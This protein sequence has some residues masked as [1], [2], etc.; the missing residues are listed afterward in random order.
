MAGVAAVLRKDSEALSVVMIYFLLSVGLLIMCIY[1]VIVERDISYLPVIA[2]SLIV[3]FQEYPK[4]I[5]GLRQIFHG[6]K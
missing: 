5:F 4:M 2:M 3:F 1:S 6:L